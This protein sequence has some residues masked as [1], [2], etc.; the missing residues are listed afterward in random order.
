MAGKNERIKILAAG[1]ISIALEISAHA[2]S[3]SAREKIEAAG[4][5]I[6][7]AE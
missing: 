4:G 2:F 1:E 6:D 3:S 7:V 5:R